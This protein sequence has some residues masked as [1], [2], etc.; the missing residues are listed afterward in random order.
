M[1]VDEKKLD[2]D[3]ADLFS[4]INTLVL[5]KRSLKKENTNESCAGRYF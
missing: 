3:I 5:Q 1:S 4:Q 2:K